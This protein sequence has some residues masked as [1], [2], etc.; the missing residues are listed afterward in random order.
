MSAVGHGEL[1][2]RSLLRPFS[3]LT[4]ESFCRKDAFAELHAGSIVPGPWVSNG[5]AW[6]A[7]WNKSFDG[8][9]L[10]V[11]GVKTL[12]G[13]LS[14]VETLVECQVNAY[15]YF[16][17]VD[18]ALVVPP[19]WDIKTKTLRWDAG[20]FWDTGAVLYI[21]MG[22]EVNPNT[23]LVEARAGFF[24]GTG[25]Q[26]RSHLIQP[27]L[28]SEMLLSGDMESL[29]PWSIDTTGAGWSAPQD[30]TVYVDGVFSAKLVSTGAAIGNVVLK[31]AREFISGKFYRYAGWYMTDPA[32]P[33]TATLYAR[34]G[35]LSFLDS[36]GRT[37]SAAD[38]ALMRN[39]GGRWR[40]FVF[41]VCAHESTAQVAIKLK[42]TAA[43]PC[44]AWIDG[45]TVKRIYRWSFYE[46]R[47]QAEGLPESEMGASDVYPGSE[48]TGGG[49]IVAANDGGAYM[50]RMVSPPFSI[51]GKPV[52]LRYGG[53]FPDGQ[54]I[55]DLEPGYFGLVSGTPPFSVNDHRAEIQVEDHRCSLEQIVPPNIFTL[56]A[57]P[58]MDAGDVNRRR[59]ILLGAETNIRPTRIAR[60]PITGLAIYEVTDP[61]F[62]VNGCLQDA[63]VFAYVDDQAAEAQ[64][65]KKRVALVKGTDFTVNTTLG[66]INIL[67]NVGPFIVTSG[68]SDESDAPRGGSDRID[69][70]SI[71]NYTASVAPGI[72]TAVG[73]ADAMA[74]AM[75][76]LLA[77][78]IIKVSYS[79]VTHKFMITN[80]AGTDLRLFLDSGAN[81]HRSTLVLAGFTSGADKIG[82]TFYEADL[83]VFAGNIPQWDA[84]YN[85]D[86]GF[87]WDV[88][89]S[90]ERVVRVDAAGYRDDTAGRFTGTPNALIE[91]GPDVLRFLL[92]W[93][94]VVVRG[95]DTTSF[96]AARTSCP[97]PLSLYLGIE[98]LTIQDVID[99]L[100]ASGFADIVVDGA[101]TVHY[102]ARATPVPADAPALYDRDYLDWDG[103]VGDNTYGTVVVQ[104]DQ[105]PV[106]GKYRSRSFTS[107][108]TKLLYVNA[109]TRTFPTFLKNEADVLNAVSKLAALARAPIRHFAFRVKGQLMTSKVGDV[110]LLTRDQ[111]LA[112][113]DENPALVA[114]PFR[115]LYLKKNYLSHGV[116][117]VAH[118]NITV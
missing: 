84:T 1:G 80:T 78:P 117:A 98:D 57:F 24:L 29:A 114:A 61:T 21:H 23:V 32:N 111:A 56:E 46:P 37:N 8:V 12:A 22:G 87:N 47:L 72:Y 103:S 92:T 42:N 74:S 35:S 9:P 99:R 70:R 40:K 52:Q 90:P 15:T 36:D 18:T 58:E 62:N 102:V 82:A 6:G 30:G 26:E 4:R 28:G 27:A 108:V 39:T 64:D 20:V 54:E 16:Y 113:T 100:E 75:N 66:R 59:N 112:A 67:Q 96:V 51:T 73:L 13:V 3:E 63:S 33:S 17:D 107:D 69:F 41:D 86:S 10:D 101:G 94:T 19:I 14:R 44:A 118:T 104:Y 109:N 97:Q 71:L 48:E 106:T 38:G 25:G 85:W 50:E 88:S 2:L 81:K 83:P 60:D 31:Q 77:S 5:G 11:V 43:T 116:S 91:L 105:H 34:F 55:L 45:L 93:V 53:A 89:P 76:A 65:P 68:I 115:L 110:V 95:L 7:A 79:N 49:R